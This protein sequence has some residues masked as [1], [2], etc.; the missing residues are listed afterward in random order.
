MD[1]GVALVLYLILLLLLL[2]MTWAIGMDVFS[3]ITVSLLLSAV[4]LIA[5]VPPTD[6]EKYTHDLIDGY[7]CGHTN[8][9]AV[10]IICSIYILTLVMVIWYVLCQ[11]YDNIDLDM[12]Y[13]R[14]K[15]LY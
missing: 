12:M 2:G 13:P 3:A 4:L 7:D 10:A 1:F 5:M 8:D 15:K 14:D 11:A 9:T 6:I